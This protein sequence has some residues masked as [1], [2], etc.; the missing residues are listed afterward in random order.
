MESI[1]AADVIVG[2]KYRL[3]RKLADGAM[4]SVWEARDES[5]DRK[6]AVKLLH[7]RRDATDLQWSY[8]KRRLMREAHITGSVRH[9]AVVRA[10]DCGVTS[11]DQP[12]F[13]MEFLGGKSL[14]RVL[15]RRRALAPTTAVRIMLPIA[16]GLAA[17]HAIGVVHRD[18]KPENVFLSFRK[19]Q[20]FEPKVIDFGVA[21]VLDPFRRE[22][23]TGRG[24][25]G[26]PGYMAP[27]Q[28]LDSSSVDGRAD[29]WAFSV[30]LYELLS[31]G[32]PFPGKTSTE[33]LSAVLERDVPPLST[34]LGLDAELWS[35][36]ERGLR[37]DRTER[38]E[39]MR[40]LSAALG[41]WLATHGRTERT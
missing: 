29:V 12:Y 37:R 22:Q 27:E 16:E 35:I 28:A 18:I 6:V 9:H 39:G 7:P 11:R 26:T 25:I 33:V 19:A 10:L 21:K 20:R 4:G 32:V 36:L 38:W 30:M 8:L 40:P 14:D 34:T 17:V 24:V 15:E 5:E 13:V 3:M 2:E 23:L 1:E 31:G 41:T